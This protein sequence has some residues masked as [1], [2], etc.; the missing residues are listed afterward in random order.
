MLSSSPTS[1][2]HPFLSTSPPLAPTPARRIRRGCTRSR[3]ER[4]RRPLRSTRF[5]RFLAAR[6]GRISNRLTGDWLGSATPTWRREPIG[7]T[8]RRMS[9]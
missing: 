5:W 7:A 8:L 2:T 4:R 1:F 3:G 6:R 9:S